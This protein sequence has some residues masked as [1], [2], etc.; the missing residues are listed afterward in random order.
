VN[1]GDITKRTAEKLGNAE[2][3]VQG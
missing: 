3:N 1:G 2:M